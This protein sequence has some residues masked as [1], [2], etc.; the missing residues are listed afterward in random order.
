MTDIKTLA[1]R[2]GAIIHPTD[3][4]KDAIAALTAISTENAELKRQLAEADELR[5]DAVGA[6]QVARDAI[7][8]A[9]QETWG[10]N[11]MGDPDVPGG[12]QEWPIQDEL[13]HN[14]DAAIARHASR[15]SNTGKE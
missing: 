1:E 8:A 4:I 7:A 12:L 5:A 9:P 10:T 13:L 11:A 15:P 6:L 3:D 2:L 14:I